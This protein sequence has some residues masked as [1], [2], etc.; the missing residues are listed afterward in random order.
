[1]DIG[2]RIEEGHSPS[3]FVT[4]VQRTQ[5]TNLWLSILDMGTLVDTFAMVLQQWLNAIYPHVDTSTSMSYVVSE[6]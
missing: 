1:M 5:R 2:I 4:G 6:I 3:Y